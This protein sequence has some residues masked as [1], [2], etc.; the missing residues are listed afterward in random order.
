[1][2]KMLGIAL[3]TVIFVSLQ[4]LAKDDRN[5]AVQATGKAPAMVRIPGKHYEIGQYHVTQA[6]WRAVMGNNPSRFADC[7]ERCPVENVSWNDTQEFIR[8]LNAQTGRHYRLPTEAEWELAC[9][10]GNQTEYCGGNDLDAVGWF[11]DNSNGKT[12]PVGQKQAN[13]YGLYDMSGNVWQWLG[14]CWG[15]DCT[16]RLLRGG[17]WVNSSKQARATV[18]NGDEVGY[19]GNDTGFRLARTL[20]S[21]RSKKGLY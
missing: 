12:H 2:L 1:M 3:M 18:R 8:K 21:H 14:D 15:G 4:A 16:K 17:A 6:E 13:V 10:A 9:H 5:L 19:A 11:A 7:G 20:P